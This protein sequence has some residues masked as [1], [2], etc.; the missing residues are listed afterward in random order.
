MYWWVKWNIGLRSIYLGEVIW[1]NYGLVICL[2]CK[3]V[4]SIVLKTGGNED[5]FDLRNA[6]SRSASCIDKVM[7]Q[8]SNLFENVY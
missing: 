6:A 7:R 5:G 8:V 2:N 1:I 3:S 4:Q